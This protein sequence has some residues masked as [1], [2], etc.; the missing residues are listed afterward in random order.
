MTDDWRVTLP[1]DGEG[2]VGEL[3]ESF[4]AGEVEH[5]AAKRLGDRVVISH[6][7]GELFLYAATEEDAR[8]AER[9]VRELLGRF[10]LRGRRARIE[11]WHPEAE[12]WEPATVPL[13]ST[14][15]ERAAEHARL[16]ETERAESRDAG[17]PGWEVRVTLRDGDAARSYAA[18]LE[19]HGLEVVRRD[20]FVMAGAETEDDARALAERLRAS[21]PDGASLEVEGT[22]QAWWS[23][24]H[25]FAVFGGLGG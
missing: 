18:R 9:V 21:A 12:R 5:E 14:D 23:A 8:T 16:M 4:R 13:P 25:P 20:R 10:K 6:D 2:V 24:L 19:A 11:R 22:G 15:E 7:G 1:Y 3:L 17:V